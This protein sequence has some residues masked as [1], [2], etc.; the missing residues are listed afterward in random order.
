MGT[1]RL[2]QELTPRDHSDL[3]RPPKIPHLSAECHANSS[4]AHQRSFC[5]SALRLRTPALHSS[6]TQMSAS[7]IGRLRSSAF[8]LSTT[9]AS[10]SLAGSCFSS[11]SALRPFHHGIRGRGG[12]I[13]GATLPDGRSKRTCEL[14][15]SVVPRGTSFHRVVELEVSSYRI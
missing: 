3:N 8:R 7:L 9:A 14:T 13:F 15:S 1:L 11:E 10:A 2:R 6:S 5:L 4:L 12:T